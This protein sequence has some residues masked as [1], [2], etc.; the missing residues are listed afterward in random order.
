MSLQSTKDALIQ[1]SNPPIIDPQ[2]DG[3]TLFSL[4]QHTQVML[5]KEEMHE[6][7]NELGA[8]ALW[9]NAKMGTIEEL[10]S[11]PKQFLEAYE[12]YATCCLEKKPIL[13]DYRFLLST[14]FT[15]D[16]QGIALQHIRENQ[17][18]VKPQK[19]V[20]QLRM[21]QMVYSQEAKKVL[22]MSLGSTTRYF[23]L[24]LSYPQIMQNTKTGVSQKL[25][26]IDSPNRELFAKF[27]KWIRRNTQPTSFW[28]NGEEIKTT[29]RLGKQCKER[30][31]DA[32]RTCLHW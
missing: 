18:L 27:R 10:K 22:S 11:S 13:Q 23:G 16:S 8:G 19:P 31:E 7:F 6:L 30:I 2:N 1:E 3:Q 28:A 17:Y 29:I 9:I 24:Q 15:Q 26:E 4:Y 14:F 21:H 12:K 25:A 5:L 32:H 20:L